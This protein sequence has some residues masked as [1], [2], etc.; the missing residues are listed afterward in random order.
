MDQV[1]GFILG[2]LGSFIFWWLFA[3]LLVPKVRFADEIRVVDRRDGKPGQR[4]LIKFWNVGSRHL[5]DVQVI[6][7]VSIQTKVGGKNSWSTSRIAFHQDGSI[8]HQMTAIPSGANRVCALHAA[9]SA[10]IA[11]NAWFSERVR[12]KCKDGTLGISEL[13][14]DGES[15]DLEVKIRISLFGYD[16]FS[17]TRKL[18]QSKNYYSSDLDFSRV[19]DADIEMSA[20]SGLD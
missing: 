6:A 13:L 16:K 8:D 5:I 17:G 11:N 15:R 3:H 20:A 9:C 2:L 4:Y 12:D 18:F 1:L 19:A 14:S 10:R 7:N